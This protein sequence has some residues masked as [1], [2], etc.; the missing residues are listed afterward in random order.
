MLLMWENELISSFFS[1]A[2]VGSTD[3]D[4]GP[5]SHFSMSPTAGAAEFIRLL[6]RYIGHRMVEISSGTCFISA[7]AELSRGVV[8]GGVFVGAAFVFM[9]MQCDR[10]LLL[11]IFS[12]R[13]SLAAVI[14]C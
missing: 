9:R 3:V 13:L 14:N 12:R 6:M 5:I 7:A 1:S 10:M 11:L 4:I 8:F 2:C